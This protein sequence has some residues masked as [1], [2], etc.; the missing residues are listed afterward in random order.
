MSSP[1]ITRS[2]DLRTSVH[3]TPELKAKGERYGYS[4]FAELHNVYTDEPHTLAVNIQHQS[5][6]FL[7]HTTAF[8]ILLKIFIF[9]PTL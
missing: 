8:R 9:S 7:Q 4:R 3:D 6:L 1:E 2:Y 5:I